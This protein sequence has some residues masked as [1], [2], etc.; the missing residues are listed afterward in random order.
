[1]EGWF[2]I[3]VRAIW[4]PGEGG[5]K[6]VTILGRKVV[7]SEGGIRYEADENHRELVLEYVGFKRIRG[8]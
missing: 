1:M 5:D 3:K 7:W 4:G 6:D 8:R 2:E